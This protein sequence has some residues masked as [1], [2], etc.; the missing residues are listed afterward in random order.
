MIMNTMAR[1][2][3]PVCFLQRQHLKDKFGILHLKP[4]FKI[5]FFFLIEHVKKR[6]QQKLNKINK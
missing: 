6:Q 3:I 2:Q 4:C 1:F 5:V